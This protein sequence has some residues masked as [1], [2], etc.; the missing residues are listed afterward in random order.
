MERVAGTGFSGAASRA[1]APAPHPTELSQDLRTGLFYFAFQAKAPAFR[2]GLCFRGNPC[3]SVASTLVL[4]RL[5]FR[6][7]VLGVLA[8]EALDTSGGIH[9]LLFSGKKR[10]ASRAYFYGDVALV[11]RPR[12]KRVAARAMHAHFV[13]SGMNGCFHMCSDLDTNP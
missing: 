8:A 5:R 12:H 3:K 2:R 13:I 10:M 4:C 6:G 7:C 1:R 9:Q 11:G